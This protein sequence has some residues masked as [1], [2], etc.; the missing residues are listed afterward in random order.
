MTFKK[1]K[2]AGGAVAVGEHGR[3]GA[4]PPAATVP[5]PSLDCTGWRWSR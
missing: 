3:G 1:L 5:R 4:V 2:I